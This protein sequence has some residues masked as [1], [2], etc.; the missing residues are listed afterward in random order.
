M[1]KA[2]S[3]QQI[4]IFPNFAISPA[5]MS[6]RTA[7]TYSLCEDNHTTDTAKPASNETRA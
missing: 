7:D 1:M 4:T 3:L 2:Y 5:L 6:F